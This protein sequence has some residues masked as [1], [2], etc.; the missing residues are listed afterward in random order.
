MKI[1]FWFFPRLSSCSS[2]YIIIMWYALVDS[3]LELTR[4]L[5]NEEVSVSVCSSLLCKWLRNGPQIR[6]NNQDLVGYSEICYSVSKFL[7]HLVHSWKFF[8]I[9][10][11]FFFFFF[12]PLKSPNTKKSTLPWNHLHSML[13]NA[14][15]EYLSVHIGLSI[16][17]WLSI[18]LVFISI[19]IALNLID[20]NEFHIFQ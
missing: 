16:W 14:K 9:Q 3:L 8:P 7:L 1:I 17:S 10:T 5:K 12:S 20:T 13:L 2:L 19:Q 18:L 6:W 15:F 11:I 4:C